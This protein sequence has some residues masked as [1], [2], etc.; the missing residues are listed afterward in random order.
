MLQSIK[1]AV[2][3]NPEDPRV[4]GCITRFQKFVSEKEL[5]GP[6]K[7]VVDQ[8]TIAF[9]LSCLKVVSEI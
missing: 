8:E 1:R 5:T 4:Q 7:Q 9:D 6:V 2:K 3:I